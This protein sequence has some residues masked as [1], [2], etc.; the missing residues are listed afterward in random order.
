MIVCLLDFFA[1]LYFES[2]VRL[3]VSFDF[4]GSSWAFG[5]LSS[6]LR[7]RLSFWEWRICFV[8]RLKFELFKKR[9]EQKNKNV[10]NVSEQK[11]WGEIS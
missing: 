6:F 7:G 11:R 10:L 5:V 1:Y 9:S 8:L 4:L 3:F 2:S